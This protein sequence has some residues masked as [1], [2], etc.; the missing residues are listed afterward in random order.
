MHDNSSTSGLLWNNVFHLHFSRSLRAVCRSRWWV[1]VVTMRLLL[2]LLFQKDLAFFVPSLMFSFD[3]PTAKELRKR[4]LLMAGRLVPWIQFYLLWNL[5]GHRA[6]VCSSWSFESAQISWMHNDAKLRRQTDGSHTNIK[7]EVLCSTLPTLPMTIKVVNDGS[8]P[9]QS[10]EEHKTKQHWQWFNLAVM[11]WP[12]LSILL[13]FTTIDS[14]FAN[15]RMTWSNAEIC[16]LQFSSKKQAESSSSHLG[17]CQSSG[18]H[19]FFH[20]SP[21][22]PFL[23]QVQDAHWY[24]KH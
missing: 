10:E 9:F 11:L 20:I 6:G 12:Q 2:I 19:F 15:T 16:D 4:G 18:S 13:Q 1:M 7:K 22:Q 3:R 21:I 24:L 23:R 14:I 8:V 5:I 17:F